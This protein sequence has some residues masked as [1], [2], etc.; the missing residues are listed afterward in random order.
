LQIVDTV[1][2]LAFLDKGDPR[3][4][5][6]SV[7]VLGISLRQDIFVPSA[8]M[9]ELDLELKTHVVNDEARVDI[10]SRLARL[11]PQSRVPASHSR[12]TWQDGRTVEGREVERLVFRYNDCCYRP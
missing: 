12:H 4:E 6:A 11:I 10:H 5:K 1:V 3:F 8:I 7:H 2:L 9:L